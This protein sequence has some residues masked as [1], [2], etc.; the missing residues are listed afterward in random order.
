MAATFGAV[1]FNLRE[2]NLLDS[3]LR[4]DL[5][6][7]TDGVEVGLTKAKIYYQLFYYLFLIPSPEIKLYLINNFPKTYSYFLVDDPK[8]RYFIE[9][10]DN[11]KMVV[12]EDFFRE[13]SNLD[14]IS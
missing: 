5:I 2:V 10:I 3:L 8:N 4:S 12:N 9:G 11:E 1:Y 7:P 13:Y 14:F 6:L